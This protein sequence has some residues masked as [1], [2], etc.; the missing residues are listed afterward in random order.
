MKV[1]AEAANELKEQGKSA[2][3]DG[4]WPQIDSQVAINKHS[5]SKKKNGKKKAQEELIEVEEEETW[6]IK[7][8]VKSSDEQEKRLA[9]T[10]KAQAEQSALATTLT[11]ALDKTRVD[12]NKVLIKADIAIADSSRA[13]NALMKQLA[14][15]DEEIEAYVKIV[16]NSGSAAKYLEAQVKKIADYIAKLTNVPSNEWKL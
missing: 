2:I 13:A 9:T 11:D 14:A 16:A 15:L 8:P 7:T 12:C 3:L 6:K 5:P 4:F 10:E 1:W